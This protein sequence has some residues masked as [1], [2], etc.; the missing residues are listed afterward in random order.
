MNSSITTYS[1]T[2]LSAATIGANPHSS[3]TGKELD[4]ETGYGYFGARYMDHELTTGWLSVD[5]MADKYPGISP[6]AYCVWNPVKLVDPDGE[7][8]NP[9][10][11]LSGSF[12]GTDDL[13]LQGDPIIMDRSKFKQG[14]SNA[15]AHKA[16]ASF[17]GLVGFCNSDGFSDFLEHSGSL[18]SRP[19]WDGIVTRE[20]GI[21]WAKEHPGALNHPTPD[22]TLYI[23]ASKLDFGNIT[24]SDFKN[25]IGEDSRIQTLNAGNFVRGLKKGRLQNTVYA[26][27]RVNLILLNGA[28]DVKVVNNEATDYDWNKGGGFIRNTL[29]MGERI[30]H[31]LNDNHGFKTYYYGAGKV[32]K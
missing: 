29:I 7:E 27:G 1:P 15:E 19:D 31:G 20:E 3:F 28:G 32:K 18:S 16:E 4:E 9:I 30:A 22:N 25:G 8:V 5:P 17:S 6:Y 14:M 2:T 11:D 21:A 23:D 26:L 10:Y 13:G 24:T 12:L